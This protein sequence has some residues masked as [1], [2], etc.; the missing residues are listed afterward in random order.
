MSDLTPEDHRRAVTG[1]RGC[2]LGVM[3]MTVLSMLIAEPASAVRLAAVGLVLAALGQAFA[4]LS[5]WL[6]KRTSGS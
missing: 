5:E 3:L 1:C 6:H 2:S 4:L